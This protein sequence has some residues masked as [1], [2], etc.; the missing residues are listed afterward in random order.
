MSYSIIVFYHNSIHLCNPKTGDTNDIVL[1]DE[2][3]AS[4]D[5]ES[6]TR[7]MRQLELLKRQHTVVMV[8]HRPSHVRLADKAVLLENGSV[9]YAGSPDKAVELMMSEK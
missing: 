9:K 2:P 8:S 7:L 6:D 3:G 5:N 1:L 4:L